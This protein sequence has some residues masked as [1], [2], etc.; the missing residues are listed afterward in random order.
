MSRIPLKRRIEL[1][2]GEEPKKNI[3][4][5]YDAMRALNSS[6]AALLQIDALFIAIIAIIRFWETSHSIALQGAVLLAIGSLLASVF[7]LF[8]VISYQWPFLG[9]VRYIKTAHHEQDTI[10]LANSIL[11]FSEEID[12]ICKAV[13]FRTMCYRAAWSLTVLSFSVSV[14]VAGLFS[15]GRVLAPELLSFPACA[16]ILAIAI[17]SVCVF[18][19]W[20]WAGIRSGRFGQKI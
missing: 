16:T 12:A 20:R 5:A 8:V 19:L 6:A 17:S 9:K 7:C 10:A 2:V 13:E 1:L 14:G 4:F 3:D 18:S 15:V 11:D